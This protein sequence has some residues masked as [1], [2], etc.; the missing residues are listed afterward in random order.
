MDAVDQLTAV[1]ADM[2]RVQGAHHPRTRE[3]ELLLAD[4]SRERTATL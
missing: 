1:L 2:V 4:W 3:T